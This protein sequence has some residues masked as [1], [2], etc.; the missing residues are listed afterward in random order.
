MK[1]TKKLNRKIFHFKNRILQKITTKFW[2]L[3]RK[4]GLRVNLLGNFATRILLLMKNMTTIG[5]HSII[6][7]INLWENKYLEICF[8][9]KNKSSPRNQSVS[10]QVMIFKSALTD[11]FKWIKMWITSEGRRFI[12]LNYQASTVMRSD[13]CKKII[14][15][16]WLLL[17]TTV[18]RI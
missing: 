10:D 7:K 1:K 5:C 13:L 11:T 3:S 14:L 9:L 8:A 18:K 12:S 6:C 16:M 15:K 4:K 17:V 2:K